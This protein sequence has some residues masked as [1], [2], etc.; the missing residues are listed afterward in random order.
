MAHV[1]TSNGSKMAPGATI[2]C[3]PF[4]SLLQDSAVCK[5]R[6]QRMLL[7]VYTD[8]RHAACEYQGHKVWRNGSSCL[9][10]TP[11]LPWVQRDEGDLVVREEKE[12]NFGT[13]SGRGGV[14]GECKREGAVL[15]RNSRDGVAFQKT[16]SPAAI[17]G[18]CRA[19]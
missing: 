2:L 15:T 4:A 1:P 16:T 10:S 9:P 7:E 13:F 11:L 14:T 6:L 17:Q 8:K 18:I 12:F 3:N 19:P 5:C